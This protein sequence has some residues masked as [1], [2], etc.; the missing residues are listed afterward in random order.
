MHTKPSQH[1]KLPNDFTWRG[2]WRSTY[3]NLSASKIAPLDCSHLY[4]DTFHR[5]FFC[6]HISLAPY[7]ENI[8]TRNQIPRLPDLTPAE[9]EES[10]I[11]K[12][13]VLTEP[14]KN[15][16]LYKTWSTET[17][18]K[19]YADTVFRI[20][21]V[22][23]PFKTYVDYM[24]DNS[25]ESPMYL[26][27]RDFVSKMGLQTEG[28]NADYTP[29]PSFGEDF[30]TILGAQRPDHQW[31]IIGPERSG[32]TFH[33]DPN[34]TSA[35]NAVVRGVKYWI[36]FPAATV[37]PG[38]YVSAD[39]SDV[40]SPLSIAEWLLNFHAAARKVPGCMEGICGEGEVLH[41]P[42]GWWHL[43]VNLSP[44]IAITQ[45]FIP[46]G[47][48]GSALDFLK[49]KAD[50]VSGFGEDVGDAYGLFVERMRDVFPD[51]LEESMKELEGKRKRKWEEVVKPTEDD[52]A[53]RGGGFSFGF[54]GDDSDIEVP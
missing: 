48:L 19:Q 23:W 9:F 24:K 33:T 15:W 12:P 8:P 47:H 35:W 52:E 46:R 44:A 5:P 26:F 29:L 37:P 50:Q 6:A 11:N 34:A 31:L 53:G 25:D 21:I 10:W 42:S 13:F 14:V 41:V 30:F 28:K 2:T 18:V 45:N 22:D 36:M 4:S 27:D 7:V 20:D 39:Q 51:V 1:R 43:V 38:V 49:N 54:G 40:T 16:P 17:L 32:S 3:L